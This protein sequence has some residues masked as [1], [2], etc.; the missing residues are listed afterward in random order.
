MDICQ[1]GLGRWGKNHARV[2]GELKR[3]GILDNVYYYDLDAELMEKTAKL[4][5]GEIVK[6]LDNIDP[7]LVEVIVPANLHYNVA[8]PFIERGI[9]TFIEKPYTDNLEDS[10]KLTDLATDPESQIMIGH[11]FRYHDGVIRAKEL[12]NS[13]IIGNLQKIDIRRLAFGYPR[14]D[15]GVIFS[16]AIHDLDLLRYF[17][18]DKDPKTIGT[19]SSTIH[20]PTEDH[21]FLH[22]NFGNSIGILEESWMSFT[23][24]KVRSLSIQGTDGEL[25]LNFSDPS[26]VRVNSKYISKDGRVIDNGI[27]AQA[28]EFNEPL[29]AEVTHFI[30]QSQNNQPYRVGP[31]IATEAVRMCEIAL[32]S[33]DQK[34]ILEYPRD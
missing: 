6:D 5:G 18:D 3:E 10:I 15:N 2:L 1:I 23:N 16:L 22:L 14:P 33:A 24:Q 8:K 20:G 26:E 31:K 19:L 13:G 4:H 25:Q 28:I 34:K 27:F 11:I 9:K 21:A 7:D 29:K 32:A 12:L 30:E 17:N